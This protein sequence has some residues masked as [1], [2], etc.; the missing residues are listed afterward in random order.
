MKLEVINKLY[1]DA[2]PTKYQDLFQILIKFWNISIDF[3]SSPKIKF[4]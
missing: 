2:R 3:R 4:T 1:Y